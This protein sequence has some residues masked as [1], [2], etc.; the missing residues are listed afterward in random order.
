MKLLYKQIL[1]K[2]LNYY[3]DF[4]TYNLFIKNTLLF[5][6]ELLNL[7]HGFL[8]YKNINT[9]TIMFIRS[10]FKFILLTIELIIIRISKYIYKTYL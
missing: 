8:I 1:I 9:T 3:I 2:I 6:Y 7:I 5:H 4:N 10:K